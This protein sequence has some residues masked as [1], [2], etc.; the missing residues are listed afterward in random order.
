MI[1]FVFSNVNIL[2]EISQN[3]LNQCFS[4]TYDSSD[5]QQTENIQ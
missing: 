4:V 2:R 1:S 5:Q 3:P